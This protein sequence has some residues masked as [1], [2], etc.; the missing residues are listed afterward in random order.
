[1]HL[2]SRSDGLI[3]APSVWKWFYQF[4]ARLVVPAAVNFHAVNMEIDLKAP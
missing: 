2:D 1:V 3:D 4:F